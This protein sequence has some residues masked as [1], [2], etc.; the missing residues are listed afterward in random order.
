M[1][2]SLLVMALCFPPAARAGEPVQAASS[3]ST[4]AAV[5]DLDDEEEATGPT[6]DP[7]Q[8]SEVVGKN[9][10]AVSDCYSRTAFRGQSGRMTVEFHIKGDG[11]VPEAKLESSDLKNTALETCVIDVV[12]KMRFP[13]LNGPETIT[14]F[15]F[16]F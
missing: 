1:V 9:G 16:I 14:T 2:A 4:T 10:W 6:L 12:K 3:T 11:T 13:A 15:P 5:H 8:V 7:K